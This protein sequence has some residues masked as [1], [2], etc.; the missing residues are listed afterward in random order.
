[1]WGGCCWAGTGFLRWLLELAFVFFSTYIAVS[2]NE[3]ETVTRLLSIRMHRSR[4]LS[5]KFPTVFA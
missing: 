2:L 4:A 5:V 1:M 3:I